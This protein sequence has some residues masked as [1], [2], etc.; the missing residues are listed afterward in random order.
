MTLMIFAGFVTA[1]PTIDI[2]ELELVK[3]NGIEV[4][5][6]YP[7]PKVKT[8]TISPS[9]AEQ[10]PEEALTFG[11]QELLKELGLSESELEIQQSYRDD[12]GTTHIYAIR[13][14]N[15]I[16]V[17][18]HN[19]AIHVKDG[20]V[21]AFSSSFAVVN[22]FVDFA[23]DAT[24]AVSL[25][26]AVT[27]ASQQLGAPKDSFPA[28]MVYVQL[29]SGEIVLAHQFQLRDDI[30]SK[31]YQVSVDANSNTVVSVVDYVQQASYKALK[32]PKGSPAEGFDTIVD[33]ADVLASPQGWHSDGA[34]KYTTTRGNNVDSRIGGTL[35]AEGGPNLEFDH[36]WDGTQAPTTDENKKA[37]IINNFYASNWIH[38]VAYQYGF[39]EKAGNFQTNNFGRGGKENDAVN[40]NN[41]APGSNN[42]NF[43]TPPD[44]Q[45]PTMNMFTWT[46]TTPQR[47]GSLENSIPIH[48]YGHGISNRMTGGSGQANCLGTTE[49]R[50]MGEGW[51][52]V[53]AIYLERKEGEANTQIAAVGSYATNRESG[54]RQYPYST[55]KTV[56]PL[57]YSNVNG[58]SSVHAIGTVWATILF[59]MYWNLVDK[60]GFSP[61]YLD[62]SQLK[63]NI[64]AMQVVIGGLA[65][66]PC[67]PTFITARDA[68]LAADQSF[69]GGQNKCL[70]WNAFAKR[71]LGT[72]AIQS[73]YTNGFEI[74]T[75]C[76]SILPSPTTTP[77]VSVTSTTLPVTTSVVVTSTETPGEPTALPTVLPTLS[78]TTSSIV[79]T[80]PSPTPSTCAHDKCTQGPPLVASCDPCVAQIIKSDPFCGRS[81]WDLIC[82]RKVTSS[83]K[84]SCSK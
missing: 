56:N 69:Y 53:F 10:A 40:V 21:L 46:M 27:V 44:G 7:T 62:A 64:M 9:F 38:D 50:G 35:R 28:S 71:G 48:E 23:I 51:S 72:N 80:F 67:N 26:E 3:R 30:Q 31:W 55:N 75:D 59:E 84:L 1:R 32:F 8:Y 34:N 4:P 45:S 61:N 79:I 49:S 73:G 78:P 29:P 42:A 11:R 39:T 18:N 25:D 13:K 22:N 16:K 81:Y 66:Q 14:I 52:D 77:V 74:P 83:C 63:G 60:H 36:Q 68:I 24:P 20:Q 54:I 5:F 43:A 57:Q 17:D 2:H 19:A 6:W 33:P 65:I 15:G 70:I 37:S 12:S 76:E 82:V 58:V 47:D 41:Q